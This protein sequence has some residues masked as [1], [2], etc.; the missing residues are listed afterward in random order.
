ME[1]GFRNPLEVEEVN[2]RRTIVPRN[3]V[4]L[5][6]PDLL[7]K[8]NLNHSPMLYI[9][10]MKFHESHVLVNLFVILNNFIG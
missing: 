7:H 2:L 9:I 5:D 1:L 4:T 3:N 8:Y 10:H 6:M